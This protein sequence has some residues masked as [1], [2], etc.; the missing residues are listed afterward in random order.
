MLFWFPSVV[1]ALIAFPPNQILCLPFFVFPSVNNPFNLVQLL[2][3]SHG[4]QRS[5]GQ[6][7]GAGLGRGAGGA[8]RPTLCFSWVPA[9]PALPAPALGAGSSALTSLSHSL[10]VRAGGRGGVVRRSSCAT[11]PPA[12][13]RADRLGL[14]AGL[15]AGLAA[16]LGA[17]LGLVLIA[18]RRGARL[19]RARRRCRAARLAPWLPLSGE[20][21]K[22][23]YLRPKH[24][25]R[26]LSKP[27]EAARP[28]GAALRRSGFSGRP[29]GRGRGAGQP[30]GAVGSAPLVRC[31]MSA[32]GC[33][34]RL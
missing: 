13:S 25:P 34:M 22:A 12:H 31:L 3:G 11:R 14:G 7:G 33:T 32:Y 4:G 19:G 16:G 9:W 10:P 24:L 5:G 15:G 20:V 1:L 30:R 28:G 23:A 17:G 6:A 8:G 27:S 18:P 21:Q 26:I 2:G 29:P